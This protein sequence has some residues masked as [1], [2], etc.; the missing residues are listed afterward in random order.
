MTINIVINIVSNGT[1]NSANSHF[2]TEI[3]SKE[4]AIVLKRCNWYVLSMV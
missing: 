1:F 4:F 3:R 2:W